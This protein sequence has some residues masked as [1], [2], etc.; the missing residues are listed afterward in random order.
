MQMIVQQR[1]DQSKD[2]SPKESKSLPSSIMNALPTTLETTYRTAR[3]HWWKQETQVA[4]LGLSSIPI[5]TC[6]AFISY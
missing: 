6:V 1:S 2:I 3:V 5:T 4:M